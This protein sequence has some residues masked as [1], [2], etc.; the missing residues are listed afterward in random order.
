MALHF[1]DRKTTTIQ[2]GKGHGS[3][4]GHFEEPGRYIYLYIP[5]PQGGPPST[6]NW[7]YNSYK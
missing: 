5:V 1:L 3:K 2:P 4:G 6:Y 7:S